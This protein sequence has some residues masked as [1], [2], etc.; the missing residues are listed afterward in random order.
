MFQHVSYDVQHKIL[1]LTVNHTENSLNQCKLLIL[2]LK[3]FPQAA[4]THSVSIFFKNSTCVDGFSLYLYN[5]YLA[6]TFGNDS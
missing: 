5:I 3:R 4:V 2:V 6:T 1:M